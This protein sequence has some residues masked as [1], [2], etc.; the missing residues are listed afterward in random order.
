MRSSMVIIK[1]KFFVHEAEPRTALPLLKREIR[2]CASYWPEY[3]TR[4]TLAAYM[5]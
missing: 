4:R 1:R 5:D 2:L 3:T